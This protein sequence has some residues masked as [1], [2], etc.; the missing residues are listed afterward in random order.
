MLA[1]VAL[2]PDTLE[3]VEVVL[4]QVIQRGILGQALRKLHTKVCLRVGPS[5]FMSD[6]ILL[7]IVIFLS[8]VGS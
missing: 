8:F 3:F 6:G 7:G 5:A 2:V 1:F 4:D